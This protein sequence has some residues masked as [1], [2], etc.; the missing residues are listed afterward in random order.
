MKAK[1]EFKTRLC[2]QFKNRLAVQSGMLVL[3]LCLAAVN[4][5]AQNYFV[6]HKFTAGFTAAEGADPHDLVSSGTTLY[7]ATSKGGCFGFGT[8]FKVNT[9]GTGFN[10][11][12]QFTEWNQGCYLASPAFSSTILYGATAWGGISNMGTIFQIN[13]DGSGFAVLKSFTG[14]LDGLTPLSDPLLSGTKLYG[15]AAGGTNN[16]GVL[17]II[18]TDGS[19]YTV[20]K[21]FTGTDGDY[22][23]DL[24][25]S[26]TTLY[27]GT[28]QGGISNMGVVFKINTN[29]SGY[30]ILKNFA[31]SDGQNPDGLLASSG[32][33]LYGTTS[34]GGMFNMGTMFRVNT[35]G[36]GF[37]VLK[38]FT[39]GSDGG[40]PCSPV[41]SGATLYGMTL[42]GGV[43]NC[44]TIFQVSTDG[45]GFTVLKNFIGGT[46]TRWPSGLALS[47]GTVYGT[48]LG[49]DYSNNYGQVVGLALPTTAPNV[50]MPPQSQTVAA[51]AGTSL[52][53]GASGFLPLAYQWFLNGSAITSFTTNSTL[54]LT[55]LLSS[56]SGLYTVVVTNLFGSV[57]SA[58]AMLDVVPPADATVRS[59]TEQAL[60]LAMTEGSQV[61]F[62]CD[63]TIVLGGSITI[64]T[65]ITLDARGHQI[66]ISGGNLVQVFQVNA[67]ATLTLMNLTIANGL[68][69]YESGIY[70]SA[71][72][73]AG[74]V[75]ASNCIFSGNGVYGAW[76]LAPYQPVNGTS[77][78]GG[79]IYNVGV[80]NADLC[81]FLQNSAGG[82]GGADYSGQVA[83]PTGP[84]S[85][86]GPGAPGGGGAIYNLGQMTITRSLFA[87]NTA[88]GGNG[89]G[90]LRAWAGLGWPYDG[91][92]GAGGNGGSGAGA[93]LFNMGTAD[94]ANCTFAWNQ[95]L[96]GNGGAGG[97]SA[98]FDWDGYH[99]YGPPGPSGTNG[100]GLGGIYN[101]NGSL[102]LTNCMVAFN[103]CSNGFVGGGG[104]ASAG[105][106]QLINTLLASNK[107]TNCSGVIT[108]LGH[109]LSSD[110][111]CA[112]AHIGSLNHTDPK[113]GPLAN[114]GGPTLTMAL[115]PGSPA[116]DAG[117]N[118]AAQPADQ[119]GFPRVV[120]PN[121][122]IGAYERCY[123]PVLQISPPQTNT[124]CL[125]VYGLPDQA[126]RLMRSS[127][128]ANW[129][130]LATN[131][132]GANGTTV[133]QDG[134]GTGQTCRFYRAMV[135]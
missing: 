9:D 94:L 99:S 63:G 6:L 62:V 108:D 18:N 21:R 107:P 60:R 17:Y 135:P 30:T 123:L 84:G 22:P 90:G 79:A 85:P 128:L 100:Y 55:N 73:N 28:W 51:G 111:S 20:L 103:S 32:A 134:C 106:C 27:G 31:G 43:S 74:T 13:T 76:P 15:T 89:G 119:R 66:T 96:G 125:L 2:G 47:G 93:A 118:S 56:Q 19:G 130:P 11:L 91:P 70:G 4:S 54:V 45:T 34:Q 50:F 129:L 120:G 61:T 116:I 105:G 29:G 104:I 52:G 48:T 133:F 33:T 77:A 1:T 126:C 121:I 44:G 65:N 131:Q 25:L 97:N 38:N 24:V 98:S 57:T 49:L 53:V 46:D 86:G 78:Y 132:I 64:T 12:K 69:T 102:N 87:S 122:D 5:K 127:T 124:V 16:N 26:G 109:N 14:G 59:C 68:G 67:D 42:Q 10:V 58:P 95:S 35:D 114:N 8:L 7:G 101:A 37:A 23:G 113:L 72:H 83:S 75:T 40:G 41:L 80:L 112:F 82:G 39:G 36:T 71:I 92:G 117:D 3:L 81:S 88:T 115:L 110:N